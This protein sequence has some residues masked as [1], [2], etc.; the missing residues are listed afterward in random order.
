CSNILTPPEGSSVIAVPAQDI[1]FRY[2]T[3]FL[4][5]PLGCKIGALRSLGK[6]KS[7]RS[8]GLCGKVLARIQKIRLCRYLPASAA[9]AV[10]AASSV[11]A[12]D[13]L[14][15]S[16]SPASLPAAFPAGQPSQLFSVAA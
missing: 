5:V 15:G 1:A 16:S 10:V 14:G 4:L 9:S 12:A 13:A 11:A 8:R 6:A 7:S 3:Q 2:A